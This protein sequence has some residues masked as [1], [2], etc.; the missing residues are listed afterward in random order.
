MI[1]PEACK[2][3]RI[4]SLWESLKVPNEKDAASGFEL[5]AR[6]SAGA[7]VGVRLKLMAEHEFLHDAGSG[8][9]SSPSFDIITAR[10]T[11]F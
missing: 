1:H 6:L 2:A 3:C 5:V 8:F 7:W 9:G 4:I 11:I 10:S